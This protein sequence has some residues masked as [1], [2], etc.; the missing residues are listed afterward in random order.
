MAHH[1][2]VR[3]SM[4]IHL[5]LRVAQCKGRCAFPPVNAMVF[6]A[7]SSEQQASVLCVVCPVLLCESLSA[8]ACVGCGGQG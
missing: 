4:R 3:I 7:A 1:L 8:R 2:L 5:P 6:L